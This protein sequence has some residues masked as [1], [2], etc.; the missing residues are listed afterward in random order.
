VG[1]FIST[2]P[3][4]LLGN[5]VGGSSNVNCY[6]QAMVTLADIRA[7]RSR[8]DGISLK[9][10]SPSAPSSFVVLTTKLRLSLTTNERAA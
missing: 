10:F 6:D 7:A 1:V 9:I 8:L 3:A 4:G 2:A 5:Q